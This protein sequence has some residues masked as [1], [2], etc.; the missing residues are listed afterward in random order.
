MRMKMV[1]RLFAGKGNA[2][3]CSQTFLVNGV[4]RS[5]GEK[6]INSPPL[7]VLTILNTSSGYLP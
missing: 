5:P 1:I 2:R 7:A 3:K 6:L 4:V